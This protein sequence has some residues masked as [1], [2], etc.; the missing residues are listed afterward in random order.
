MPTL[1]RAAPKRTELTV[2]KTS[3]RLHLH[4]RSSATNAPTGAPAKHN[5]SPAA[6]LNTRLQSQH[7]TFGRTPHAD[8]PKIERNRNERQRV[9][10]EFKLSRCVTLAVGMRGTQQ[11]ARQHVAAAYTNDMMR[12]PRCMR[13]RPSPSPALFE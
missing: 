9:R 12:R 11:R 7:T 8:T 1:T 2:C 6:T 10:V 4:T 3:Q 5:R 13:L